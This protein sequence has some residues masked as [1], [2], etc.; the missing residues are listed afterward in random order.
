M[1]QWEKRPGLFKSPETWSALLM[2]GLTAYLVKIANSS[3]ATFCIAVGALVIVATSLPALKRNPRAL[4]YRIVGAGAVVGVAQVVFNVRDLVIKALGRNPTL[5]DRTFVWQ[6][7]L[8]MV[9]N[10]I[11]GAGYESFWT[12]ARIAAVWDTGHALQAH[13]GFIDTYLNLGFVGV[14]F[15]L[16]LLVRCFL[17][18]V[19]DM[20]VDFSFNQLRLSFLF[21]FCL[22]N[23]TEAA[24]PRTGLLLVL[25]FLF[26][27]SA[28]PVGTGP[29]ADREAEGTA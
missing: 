23:Y 14:I 12:S 19:G 9:T 28:G 17:L 11:L 22:Y 8:G 10:P 20:P 7:V 1:R 3:T 29:S 15:F 26:V 24:F 27:L 4:A 25:F 16:A 2:L 6:T 21:I 5:T 13:N 18:A